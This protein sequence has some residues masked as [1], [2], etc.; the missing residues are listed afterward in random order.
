[1]YVIIDKEKMQFVY[2]HEH[3]SVLSKLAW[4]ELP[5][6]FCRIQPCDI[7]KDF[8]GLTDLELKLL[9]KNSNG[10]DVSA[11]FSR[12]RLASIACNV[13]TSLPVRELNALELDMQWRAIP[14]GTSER[15]RYVPGSYVPKVDDGLEE[16]VALQV[17]LQLRTPEQ[18]NETKPLAPVV[19]SPLLHSDGDFTAPKPGTS[20]HRIFSFCASLWK[21]SGYLDNKETLDKIRKRAVEVLV[22]EG[23]NIS[24]VRTQAARWHQNRTRFAE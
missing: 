13:A 21:E 4:I 24:T 10:P 18:L 3:G 7:P 14:E 15:Y 22:P 20:T 9:I 6:I 5:H 16:Y 19:V 8:A 11:V 2:K 1:M 23:L 17:P 12:E